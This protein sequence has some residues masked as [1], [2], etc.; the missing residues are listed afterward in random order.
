[1][2]GHAP[3]PRQC[4]VSANQSLP[5]TLEDVAAGGMTEHVETWKAGVLGLSWQHFLWAGVR[6]PDGWETWLNSQP[7]S[8]M[9]GLPAQ[10]LARSHA[11]HLPRTVY[12]SALLGHGPLFPRMH[13]GSWVRRKTWGDAESNGNHSLWSACCV[14]L[15][16]RYPQGYCSQPPV[17]WASFYA[18]PLTERK[19]EAWV[20]P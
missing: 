16:A 17:K 9:A 10:N 15:C 4:R 11:L 5:G 12:A 7:G 8:F 14:P 2:R 20:A 18:V 3:P 1:M 13:S 19:P 6:W